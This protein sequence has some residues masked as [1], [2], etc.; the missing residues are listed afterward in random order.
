[1]KNMLKYILFAADIFALVSFAIEMVWH[2]NT[3]ALL[4]L[5][6]CFNATFCH[7]LLFK[8]KIW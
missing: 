8:N 1:M 4:G 2:N 3:Y 5:I 6:W 7:Y